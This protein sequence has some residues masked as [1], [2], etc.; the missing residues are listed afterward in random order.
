ME[1]GSRFSGPSPWG[2]GTDRQLFIISRFLL[3]AWHLGDHYRWLQLLK[4]APG[5]NKGMARM[6]RFSFTCFSFAQFITFLH[7][8]KGA[9]L[10][11]G[12]GNGNGNGGDYK[13]VDDAKVAKAR[14]ACFKAALCTITFCHVSELVKSHDVVCGI[15]AMITSSMDIYDIWPSTADKLKHV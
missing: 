1:L 5:G 3:I 11:G 12:D 2:G 4:W 14:R 10:D 13:S 15:A 8:F 7:H 6:R 9:F